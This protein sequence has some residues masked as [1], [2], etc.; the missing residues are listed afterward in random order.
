MKS[1]RYFVRGNKSDHYLMK[2]CSS[3]SG[4][5]VGTNARNGI[6]YSES[7]LRIDQNGRRIC[8]GCLS[9]GFSLLRLS[10][11]RKPISQNQFKLLVLEMVAKSF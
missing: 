1:E 6:R 5:K 8:Y 3:D 9:V 11:S 4:R 2:F 10:L 7:P